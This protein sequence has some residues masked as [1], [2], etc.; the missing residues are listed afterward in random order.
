PDTPMAVPKRRT[1]RARRGNRRLHLKIESASLVKC[2]NCS[3]K[4][5]PHTVC[6][7]CGHYRGKQVTPG[8]GA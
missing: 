8:S 5:R 6:S 4:I 1:S 2:S 7:A 3:T